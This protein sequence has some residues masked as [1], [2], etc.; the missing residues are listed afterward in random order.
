MNA[1]DVLLE[2][3]RLPFEEST[4]AVDAN[5]G[6]LIGAENKTGIGISPACP[7][8]PCAGDPR[9]L[10]ASRIRPSRNSAPIAAKGCGPALF[11]SDRACPRRDMAGPP[12]VL[13][14]CPGLRSERR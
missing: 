8:A 3:E 12:D 11:R 13:R 14:C 10:N 1:I 2:G 9:L 4:A 6:E 5:E 7:G